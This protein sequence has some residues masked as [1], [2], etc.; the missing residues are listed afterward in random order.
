M[1][2]DQGFGVIVVDDASSD[3]SPRYLQQRLEFL[4]DRLTLVRHHRRRGRMFNNVIAIREL[5]THPEAC[6]VVVDLDDTLAD[7]VAI[8]SVRE[9]FDS[10]HD[11]VLAAPFRPEAPTKVYQPDFLSPRGTFGGDVWIHLRAFARRLFNSIPDD[12]LQL[13]GEWLQQCDDYA[14][15]VPIVELAKAPVYVPEYWYWHE[16]T[17]GWQPEERSIRDMTILRLLEKQSAAI[18]NARDQF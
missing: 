18:C 3:A 13:D 11:V 8:G 16:R 4:G 5:C 12:A 2:L 14:I 9:L 7:P 6:I 1:Q 10:G 15:M 17:T